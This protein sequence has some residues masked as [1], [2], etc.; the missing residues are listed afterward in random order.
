M[1]ET[2]HDREQTYKLP[3]PFRARDAE[4]AA[5]EGTYQL[6]LG[7]ARPLSSEL[8]RGVLLRARKAPG[9]DLM[10]TSSPELAVS[11]NR[12]GIASSPPRE[13]VNVDLRGRQGE[14][15]LGRLSRRAIRRPTS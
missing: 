5:Q 12:R 1:Q 14:E 2:S 9:L 10:A 4:S 3:D 11:P 15:Y 8:R 6:P 7:A 13:L